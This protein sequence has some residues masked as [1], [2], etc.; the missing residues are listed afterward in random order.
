MESDNILRLSPHPNPVLVCVSMS[1]CVCVCLSD[2]VQGRKGVGETYLLLSLLIVHAAVP[3]VPVLL[4]YTVLVFR[5]LCMTDCF[6]I[7]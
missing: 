7:V 6:E 1:I 5:S 3:G 2:G 4:L